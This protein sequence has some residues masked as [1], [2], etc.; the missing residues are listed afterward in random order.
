[1]KSLLALLMLCAASVN[2]ATDPVVGIYSA[3]AGIGNWINPN[4]LVGIVLMI[5]I[6]WV[7]CC[8]VGALANI[9]CPRIMLEKPLEWGKVE[10]TEE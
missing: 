3:N 4:A 10:K 5:M 2:A 6:F 8:V 1:M 9:N 7:S